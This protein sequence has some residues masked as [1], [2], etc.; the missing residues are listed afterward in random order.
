MARVI[1]REWVD[2]RGYAAFLARAL[3]QGAYWTAIDVGRSATPA[4]GAMRK[5]R[6]VKAGIP[7][8]LVVWRGITLWIEVKARQS[9]SPAQKTTRDVLLANGHRWALARSG[10]DVEAALRGAGIPLFATY[11]AS[12]FERKA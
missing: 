12:N 7:D 10:E 11:D 3:P 2:Q 9:L 4:Q 5:A 6:G 1:Q 8:F